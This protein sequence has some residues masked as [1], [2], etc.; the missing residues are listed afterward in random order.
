MF[1]H[2]YAKTLRHASQNAITE[3]DFQ[4]ILARNCEDT[5]QLQSYK[6]WQPAVKDATWYAKKE[7][8][9]KENDKKYDI[10]KTGKTNPFI[11]AS[12]DCG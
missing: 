4:C 9:K 10:R 3:G 1:W 2:D 6:N 12:A 8:M 5:E 7:R 11:C